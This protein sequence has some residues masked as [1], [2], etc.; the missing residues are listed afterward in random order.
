MT[1]A[2]GGE[3]GG[4]VR[5]AD[6]LCATLEDLRVRHVFGL[7]GTQNLALAEAL[8]RSNTRWIVPSNELA[9]AF[10]A[11]GYYRAS[12]RP[13][14]VLT[15]PGPGFTWALTGMAEARLDSA[16][17]L[18]I[19]GDHPEGE[20]GRRR[21]QEI[22]QGR[23]AESVTAR[24][25]RVTDSAALPGTIARAHHASIE[26]EPG[27]VLVEVEHPVW[28][29]VCRPAR[30]ASSAGVA[31]DPSAVEVVAGRLARSRRPVLIA[32]QGCQEG[33]ESLRQVAEAL[34]APVILS[35]SGRGSLPDT[36]PLAAP[37]DR[38]ED[39]EEGATRLIDESDLVLVL[40]C[41][42]SHNAT[43]GFRL[44]LPTES[45]VRVDASAE[46]LADDRYPASE[47]VECDVPGL[48][49]AL[50]QE[51]ERSELSAER[52]PGGSPGG[53]GGGPV[54]PSA[55]PDLGDG[56]SAA[57]FFDALRSAMPADAPLVTDS[58]LHQSMVRR[59][60]R[61]EEPRTLVV[62]TNFQ[63]MGYGVPAAIGAALARPESPAVAVVGDGGLRLSA[64]EIAVARELGLDL[65][66]IVFVD[67]HFGLIRRGQL[68]AY[69]RTS[70]VDLP[71]LDLGSL[72]ASLGI[73]HHVVVGDARPTLERCVER[74]GVH[75][76]AVPVE[77][78]GGS[79]REVADARLREE[80]RR[81]LGPERMER[82]RRWRG[83]WRSW[84]G[85]GDDD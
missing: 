34:S 12:G 6:A 50:L 52:W 32:G 53:G 84:K 24:R 62:P 46:V 19:T 64:F 5:A 51:P 16:A 29:G 72:A 44:S 22:P 80:A 63:S 79:W 60:F 1:P 66:V 23:M 33:A 27:P 61:V 57:A 2:A 15:I 70:G 42:L 18:W 14:V 54:D 26:G 9:A 11:N 21:L 7:P 78:P 4:A 55:E 59:H 37:L 39:P 76:V 82:L 41:G 45:L 73:E 81:R 49:D 65:T 35:T 13:G 74:G 47:A 67:G 77:D 36:H 43:L 17:V 58:G 48:L 71:A 20:T 8:R 56:G 25:F 75:L 28:D 69:G 3:G 38:M 30:S 68:E 83:K 31:P 40:G 10:M 85:T